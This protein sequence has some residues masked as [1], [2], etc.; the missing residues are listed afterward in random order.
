MYILK[1]KLPEIKALY[2]SHHVKSLHA[3]GSVCTDDFSSGSDVDL[4]V[5]FEPLDF[6][7][8]ADHYFDLADHLEESLK[9][10]VDLV[11]DESLSNPYFIESLAKSKVLLYGNGN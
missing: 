6:G 11:T 7:D 5:S 4:L 2:A 9:R 3:F 1:D 8:Y 10:P